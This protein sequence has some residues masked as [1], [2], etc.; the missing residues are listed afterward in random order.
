MSWVAS[1][2]SRTA[3]EDPSAMIAIWIGASYSKRTLPGFWI[4]KSPLVLLPSGPTWTKFPTS[5][6]SD[7]RYELTLAAC[8]FW[9]ASKVAN[10]LAGTLRC[11]LGITGFGGVC[12]APV[13]IG[14]FC[15]SCA[16]ICTPPSRAFGA[17]FGI[18]T[19]CEK[20]DVAAPA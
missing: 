19:V 6:C 7:D 12:V 20:P 1:F 15:E 9:L 16:L 8:A 17:G 14:P 4:T 5:V 11:G 10:I 13:V 18:G 3:S 2:L